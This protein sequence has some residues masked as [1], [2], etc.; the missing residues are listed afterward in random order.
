MVYEIK[1]DNC[2]KIIDFGGRR[3]EESLDG[4]KEFP[5]NAM[6]FDGSVYCR[7][8]IQDLIQF[9]AGDIQRRVDYVMNKMD[10]VLDALGIRNPGPGSEE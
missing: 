4:S 3:P 2:G 8:C 5:E 10:E 9:G 1:C 7:E 6:K